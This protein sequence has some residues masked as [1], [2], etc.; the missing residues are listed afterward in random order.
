MSCRA[1]TSRL[2]RLTD[3]KG[4]IKK[5]VEVVNENQ[6]C[7]FIFYFLSHRVDVFFLAS[8]N[9]FKF[10]SFIWLVLFDALSCSGSA[11]VGHFLRFILFTKCRRI[12]K[13][14]KWRKKS[15]LKLLIQLDKTSLTWNWSTIMGNCIKNEEKK[16]VSLKCKLSPTEAFF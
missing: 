11:N 9:S 12:L 5:A 15:S 6:P 2:K 14:E 1:I 16:P 8:K 3:K 7:L 13:I 10:W 4:N